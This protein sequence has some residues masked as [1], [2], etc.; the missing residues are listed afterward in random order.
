[1]NTLNKIQMSSKRCRP[2]SHRDFTNAQ[3]AP[4]C[5]CARASCL[6]CSRCCSDRASSPRP[7]SPPP[8]P[9]RPIYSRLVSRSLVLCRWCSCSCSC[10]SCRLCDCRFVDVASN[11]AYS[12]RSVCHRG[13]L[14]VDLLQHSRSKTELFDVVSS[15]HRHQTNRVCC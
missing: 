11:V 2:S 13:V 1:M 12:S 3:N 7:P 6:G 4:H 14:L 15:F 8:T 5:R 9:V 10:C